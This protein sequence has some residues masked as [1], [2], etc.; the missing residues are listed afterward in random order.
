MWYYHVALLLHSCLS[1]SFLSFIF[2][3]TELFL[4]Y[5]TF[6]SAFCFLGTFPISFCTFFL[7]ALFS[8]HSFF[9][10][11]CRFECAV[12]LGFQLLYSQENQCVCVCVREKWQEVEEQL[13]RQ[14]QVNQCHIHQKISFPMFPTALLVL[15][16]GVSSQFCVFLLSKFGVTRWKFVK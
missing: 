15:L 1:S 9:W 3:V 4:Y 14:R 12:D 13:Q 7:V 11:I 16:H 10:E 8:S 5:K 6:S 2:S